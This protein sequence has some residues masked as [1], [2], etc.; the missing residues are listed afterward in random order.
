MEALF[1]KR[2]EESR[3]MSPTSSSQSRGRVREDFL[4]EDTPKKTCS[5]GERCVY[6]YMAKHFRKYHV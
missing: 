6:I 5:P 4:E 3:V 1:W 2:L